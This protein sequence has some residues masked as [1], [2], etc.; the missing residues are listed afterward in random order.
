MENPSFFD[1]EGDKKI[2]RRYNVSRSV[3]YKNQ[4]DLNFQGNSFKH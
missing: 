1:K 4:H 3:Q 2:C